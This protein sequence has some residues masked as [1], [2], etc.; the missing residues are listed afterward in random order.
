MVLLY[1][2]KVPEFNLYKFSLLKIGNRQN[3]ILNNVSI[4]CVIISNSLQFILF[5]IIP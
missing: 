4:I 2:I 3:E 1:N 5:L